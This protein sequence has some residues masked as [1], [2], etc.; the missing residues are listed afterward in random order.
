MLTLAGKRPS[1]RSCRAPAGSIA[2]CFMR[3]ALGLVPKSAQQV[4]AAT[5]RTVFAQPD[6]AAAR[7]QGV[8]DTFRARFARLAEMLDA[9][10]ADVLAYAK[11]R[12]A[13]WH[14]VWSNN[15][16]MLAT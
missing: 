12:P 8:A 5:I 10:E 14:Q 6:A 4:V 3:D 13:H 2:G 16:L 11:F 9:A 15:P 7:E 1:A